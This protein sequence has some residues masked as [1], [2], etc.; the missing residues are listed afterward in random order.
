MQTTPWL[1]SPQAVAYAAIPGIYGGGF[2]SVAAFYS[3]GAGTDT[4]TAVQLRG[5]Y[6]RDGASWPDDADNTVLQTRTVPLMLVN[7]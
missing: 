6:S 2:I 4:S 1:N 3:I 5:K 7:G